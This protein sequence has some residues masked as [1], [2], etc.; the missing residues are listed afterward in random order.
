MQHIVKYLIR[1]IAPQSFVRWYRRRKLSRM[2]KQFSS[3]SVREAFSRI[4]DENLWGGIQGEICSGSGSSAEYAKAYANAI[5]TF[6]ATNQIK[7]IL[8]L[9]C[10]DFT[11]GKTI[12]VPGTRYIGVDVVP[13]V[14][15]RNKSLF[16]DS[17]IEFRCMDIIQDELPQADLCLIRQVLQHFSNAQIE[18]VLRKTSQFRWLI[19]TEHLPSS[20]AMVE[21]N[22]DKPHGPDTRLV[23][24]SGVYLEKP[25]FNRK[26]RKVLLD[27]PVTT[28]LIADGERFITLVFSNDHSD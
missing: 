26:A 14:V 10:G 6:V 19:I 17:N 20:D 3:L 24:G 25:P 27:H 5:R 8:D 16:Q 12:Q 9:G 18:A 13:R 2:R 11:V 23:D 28:P 21:P 22:L 1:K 15:E 4:Y 7:T